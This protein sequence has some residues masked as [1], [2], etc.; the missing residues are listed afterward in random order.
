MSGLSWEDRCSSEFWI[1][2]HEIL[3]TS[4]FGVAS[5]DPIL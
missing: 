1:V 4:R 2:F 3:L 5:L